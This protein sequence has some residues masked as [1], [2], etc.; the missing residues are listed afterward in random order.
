M[1]DVFTGLKK[2]VFTSKKFKKKLYILSTR[3]RDKRIYILLKL[4]LI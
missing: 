4:Y 1:G 3:K 2:I